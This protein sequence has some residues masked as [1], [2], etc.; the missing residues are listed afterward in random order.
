MM[1]NMTKEKLELK[2][3]EIKKL[4]L[5]DM[6][7]W[8][9]GYSGGK[10]STVTL[11]LIFNA[12]LQLN[13]DDRRKEIFVVSSDTMIENPKVIS[14]LKNNIELINNKSLE[15]G[16]PLKAFLLKP[17]VEDT[18]WTLLI[19]KGY[20]TP[21]QKFR[22]CTSR[23]KIKPI[24]AF[25]NEST[26]KNDEVI[27]VLGVRNAESNSRKESIKRRTV[28]G[29]LLKVHSTNSKAY[30]YAPIEHFGLDDVWYYLMNNE[31]PWGNN[32]Q[33]LLSLYRDS[34][35]EQECPMQQDLEAP[36]CG[37]SRF[38]CW[39]CTVVS[40]DKS[41][42]GFIENGSD[43]LYPLLDFRG[44][45]VEMRDVP[46]NRQKWRTN[47]NIYYL[48]KDGKKTVGL[49]PFTLEAR[50]K[51]L[52]MLLIAEKEYNAQLNNDSR[53][54]LITDEELKEI[55]SIWIEHG[56][57]DDSVNKITK[58]IRGESILSDESYSPIFG[59]EELKL[60][61]NLCDENEIEFNLIKQLLNIETVNYGLKRRQKAIKSISKLMF[62][63]RVHK[64]II[65]Q[66]NETEG[67]YIDED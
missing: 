57:W 5:N 11:Q 59:K 15:L 63:D 45:L 9:I 30:V 13:P 44:K 16:L 22:W 62:Q 31:N 48:V 54:E 66:F 43:E 40:I 23:L 36:S 33:E 47:G 64:E 46:S 18:F 24:D 6:R 32:N 14:F 51:I 8:I 50:K 19:G 10:D 3:E 42:T 58:E 1:Q 53:Y 35:D 21:R 17:K 38:G 65:S 27:V 56:D 60:L 4:Y 49:G 26:E 39:V 61:E 67:D 34:M 7:P 55:N 2:Y 12:L 20:P 29:K 37:N 52:R 41:L 25:I 28:E